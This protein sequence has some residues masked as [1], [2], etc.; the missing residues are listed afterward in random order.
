MHGAR[1]KS[2]YSSSRCSTRTRSCRTALRGAAAY[3]L[4]WFDAH[5]WAY[6]ERYGLRE[7]ISEDFED[8]RLYGTVQAAN[9]FKPGG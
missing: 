9:P 2:C 5:M 4:A 3:G 8:G 6:A 7:L 1:L